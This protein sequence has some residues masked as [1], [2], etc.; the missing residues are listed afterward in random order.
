VHSRARAGER[1]QADLHALIA[2]AAA[3]GHSLRKIGGAAGLSH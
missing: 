2:Q 1:A 3:E